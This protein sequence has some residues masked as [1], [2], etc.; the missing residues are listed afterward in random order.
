MDPRTSTKQRGIR[1][2]MQVAALSVTA[3][4]AAM[5]VTASEAKADGAASVTAAGSALDPSAG[6]QTPTAGLDPIRVTGWSCWAVHPDDVRTALVDSDG[7]TRQEFPNGSR[8][9]RMHSG[10]SLG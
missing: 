9:R 10:L 7:V 5:A 1:I 4:A 8:R 3:G 6:S 2:A